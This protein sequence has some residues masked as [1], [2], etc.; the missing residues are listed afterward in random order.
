MALA[1]NQV[2]TVQES[3]RYAWGTRTGTRTAADF[4]IPLGF[5]PTHIRVANLTDRIF[6][7]HIVDAALG[8]SNVESIKS[9]AAGTT[10]YEDCGITLT[11]DTKG[12]TVD[13]SVANLET[14]NDDTYW[15]AWA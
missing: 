9:V 12:F 4:T 11:S 1:S 7:L 15:E 8:T 6:A 2:Q 5:T 13:V 3:K 14:D 10:T